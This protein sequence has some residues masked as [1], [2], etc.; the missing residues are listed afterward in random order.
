MAVT[1][2][3]SDDPTSDPVASGGSVP[4]RASRT[5]MMVAAYRGRSSSRPEP[6]FCDPWATALAGDHGA[7]LMASYD[8]GFPHMELWIAM[9]TAFIDAQ[10]AR[11]VADDVQ[12]VVLLGAGFDTRA[13]RLA[14][15]G[16]RF[17]ELDQPASQAEK[18]ARLATL[19]GYPIDA[20]TYVP[21][22][23]ESQDFVEVLLAAGYRQDR[24]TLFIWEGVTF[25]LTEPAVRGT[26]A[27][28]ASGSHPRSVLVFDT[29]S[30]RFAQGDN[31]EASDAQARQMVA[32]LGEPFRFGL[33]DPIPLLFAAGFRHVRATSFDE[34]CLSLT[35]TYERER[36]LRFQSMVLASAARYLEP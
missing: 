12:Q 20:A 5:A 14:S 19:E 36:K 13:A 3:Q 9:R 1:T 22:D 27:R 7:Q 24:P 4:A 32:D 35:G 17:F 28:V 21:C 16:V 31:V 30:R 25:Y 10:L 26:A 23:F 29:I 8:A 6:L 33:D 34:I 18:R 2:S 15:P 11:L